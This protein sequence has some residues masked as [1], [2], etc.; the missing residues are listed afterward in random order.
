MKRRYLTNDG[1]KPPK[2][3]RKGGDTTGAGAFYRQQG[4]SCCMAV[5]AF[6][7][8]RSKAWTPNWA[9]KHRMLVLGSPAHTASSDKRPCVFCP[10]EK[11]GDHW[12]QSYLFSFSFFFF[13]VGSKG[14]TGFTFRVTHLGLRQ[15]RTAQSG[16]V[17]GKSGVG[18][19]RE[20]YGGVHAGFSVLRYILIPQQ[21][22]FKEE[23]V[24]LKGKA[25]TL[26]F[27]NLFAHPTL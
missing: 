25:I 4:Q 21:P 18:G 12:R 6:P 5:G 17:R 24:S 22:F 13:F 2:T 11:D 8:P 1:Q 27:K 26:P 20:R 10:L 14:P 16:V 15:G 19:L 3:D 23:Q 7:G 9:S